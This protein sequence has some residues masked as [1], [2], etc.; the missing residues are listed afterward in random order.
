VIRRHQK[1]SVSNSSSGRDWKLDEVPAVGDPTH[2]V[3]IGR[4][5]GVSVGEL[6]RRVALQGG[7]ATCCVVVVR[8]GQ[9]QSHRSAFVSR[10]RRG[11]DRR[12]TCS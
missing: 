9:A 10:T 8:D 2:L 3:Q 1:V 7:V 11:C 5:H 6:Q 12:S 4:G